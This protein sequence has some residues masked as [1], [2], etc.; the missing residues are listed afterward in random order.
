MKASH[1]NISSNVGEFEDASEDTLPV[2]LLLR[3]KLVYNEEDNTD[4]L[5]IKEI[6]EEGLLEEVNTEE[7]VKL[8]QE[9]EDKIKKEEEEE[10][11]KKEEEEKLRKEKEEEERHKK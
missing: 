6:K 8:K 7:R 5:N 1:E 2:I 11:L 10:Q 9:L 4:L 3:E